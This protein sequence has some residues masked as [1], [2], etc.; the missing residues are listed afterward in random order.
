MLNGINIPMNYP[1]I[2]NIEQYRTFLRS[3]GNRGSGNQ[4]GFGFMHKDS[5]TVDT[6]NSVFPYYSVVYVI[7]GQGQYID[8]D[9]KRY[10]LFPGSVFQRIPEK[11]H[12]II[13]EPTSRWAECFMDFGN[14]IYNFLVSMNVIN[15][16]KPVIPGKENPS[17]EKEIYNL[18]YELQNSVEQ[19][20]PDILLKSIGLLR[21]LLS[22]ETE[23]YSGDSTL[24][25]IEKCCRDLTKDYRE[26]INLKD[27]CRAGGIGYESFRK[28]FRKIIGLPP[29]KYIIRQR[30]N[31]ASH[32][33]LMT[34]KSIGEISDDL[35]YKS[36]NEFSSQFKEITGV[37]P[38]YYRE[39]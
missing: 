26:R 13:L 35:G 4:L 20:L 10:D 15:P 11:A 3:I 31:R 6:D 28:N 12:S 38:G 37:S 33:L 34:E 8:R 22:V 21:T 14:D 1:G 16:E 39:S 5:V 29:G 18:L 9:G 24:S 25:Q 2:N 23:S 7:R 36:Q 30:I 32:L 27:Y 17:V 19:K